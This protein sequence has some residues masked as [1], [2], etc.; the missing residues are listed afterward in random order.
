MHIRSLCG[1]CI[2]NLSS[3]VDIF[4]FSDHTNSIL[5]S[6]ARLTSKRKVR[7][8]RSNP[9][10]F[11][12]SEPMDE[13]VDDSK[14]NAEQ[15]EDPVLKKA[16]TDFE[17]S[18]EVDTPQVMDKLLTRVEEVEKI[19]EISEVSD[20]GSK[21]EEHGSSHESKSESKSDEKT[22]EEDAYH[23]S[24]EQSDSASGEE[25]G[26]KKN[27]KEE[28]EVSDDDEGKSKKKKA[29]AIR[30][31][32]KRSTRAPSAVVETNGSSNGSTNGKKRQTRSMTG[33][34]PS[35]TKVVKVDFYDKEIQHSLKKHKISSEAASDFFKVLLNS[36]KPYLKV[37]IEPILPT[38]N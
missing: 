8:T 2:L 13:S 3:P 27:T 34:K 15:Q 1:T 17:D 36:L 18:I 16:K 23:G 14:Q 21:V 35:E 25:S 30:V 37:A 29:T 10:Q 33:S 32:P 5:K 19:K 28:S 31:M 38:D 12:Q 7:S 26:D 24:S 6:M 9:E 22:E 4:C 20:K 11:V